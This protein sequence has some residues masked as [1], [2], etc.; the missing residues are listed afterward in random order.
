MS[1]STINSNSHF[2]PCE[3]SE[4]LSHESFILCWMNKKASKSSDFRVAPLLFAAQSLLFL[5]CH[6]SSCL[7]TTSAADILCIARWERRVELMD[8]RA[9]SGGLKRWILSLSN[10]NYALQLSRSFSRRSSVSLFVCNNCR[11]LW[12]APRRASVTLKF[13]S[14]RTALAHV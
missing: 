4:C 2:E 1:S 9:E 7:T 10:V 6:F 11:R 13:S 14:P 3:E 8:G 5:F 12:W